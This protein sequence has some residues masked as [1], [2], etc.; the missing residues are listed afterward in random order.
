MNGGGGRG[1]PAGLR[2]GD[3]PLPPGLFSYTPGRLF[4]AFAIM[5]TS[6]LKRSWWVWRYDGGRLS[7]LKGRRGKEGAPCSAMRDIVATFVTYDIVGY[8]WYSTL[9]GDG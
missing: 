2:R 5:C 8:L 4:E 3:V 1:V 9:I 7:F 6:R